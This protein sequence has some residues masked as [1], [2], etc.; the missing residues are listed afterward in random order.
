[1]SSESVN[2]SGLLWYSEVSLLSSFGTGTFAAS[3]SSISIGV[4]ELGPACGSVSSSSSGSISGLFALGFEDCE[5]VET[6]TSPP[7]GC[8][9]KNQREQSFDSQEQEL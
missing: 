2:P 6:G 5:E 1:M 9:T 7:N 3:S 4:P 8:E